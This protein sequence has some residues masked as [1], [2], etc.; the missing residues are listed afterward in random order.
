MCRWELTDR[1]L[2]SLAGEVQ[3]Q[4]IVVKELES[5]LLQNNMEAGAATGDINK[6]TILSAG[7]N[8]E[9][10]EEDH[11]TVSS[12]ENDTSQLNDILESELKNLEDFA[13]GRAEREFTS[14]FIIS[15]LV[16]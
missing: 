3:V 15:V 12:L 11:L 2:S 14:M 6:E 10:G 13:A 7:T 4:S 8:E 16:L 5:R 1:Q 9:A